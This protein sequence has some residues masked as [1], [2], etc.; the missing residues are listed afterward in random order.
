MA[1]KKT[2]SLRNRVKELRNVRASTLIPSPA[3]WRL[4]PEEQRAVMAGVFEDIGCADALLVREVEGGALQIIDG[5]LRADISGDAEVPVLVLD[6]DEA[7][8]AYLL[9]TLDPIA[10]MAETDAAALSTLLEELDIQNQDVLAMV[11]AMEA[12][13]G[14][15]PP[16]GESGDSSPKLGDLE[17]RI[18]VDC[19]DEA[20]QVELLDRFEEEGLACRALIS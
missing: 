9:A 19:K 8:A 3:N 1:K 11:E 2:T 20:Q 14:Y 10:A 6:L 4:H 5:H 15:P 13:E 17:Y 16:G 7:E 12:G 18:I